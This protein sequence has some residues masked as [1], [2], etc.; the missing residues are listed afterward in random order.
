MFLVTLVACPEDL[1][2]R[3]KTRIE[4]GKVSGN[5]RLSETDSRDSSL[6]FDVQCRDWRSYLFDE[7]GEITTGSI[8]NAPR[9]HLRVQKR[10]WWLCSMMKDSSKTNT[11]RGAIANEDT[12]NILSRREYGR[13]VSDS[14]PMPVKAGKS[15]GFQ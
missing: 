10:A 4:I 3:N 1:V 15:R 9:S 2:P 6:E 14:D 8:E 13:D 5:S 12:L 11:T 7:K